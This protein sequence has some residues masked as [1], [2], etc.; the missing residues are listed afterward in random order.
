M[1]IDAN[2]Q[3][4]QGQVDASQEQSAQPQLTSLDSLSEFE[5]QGQKFTPERL[6]EMLNGYQSLSKE[7]ETYQRYK[8]YALNVDTDIENVLEGRASAE[9]FKSV[10][11]RE[12][13]EKL[14]RALQHKQGN[15]ANGIPKEFLNEFGQLKSGYE[16]M[17]EQLHQMAM[18]SANAKIEAIL[19]K[20]LDKYPLATEDMILAKAEAFLSSGG[21]MTDQAWE[22]LA[23]ESHEMID[24]RAA[25]YYKKSLQAQTEKGL[26]AKDAGPGGATP[27][28]APPKM[29]SFADAEKAMIAELKSQGYNAY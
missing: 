21:R 22:R 2:V 15:Q 4:E 18:E 19:P 27:G 13:H 8:D 26:Q 29:K 25:S 23:K 3:P 5:F 14:E 9:K 6:Q 17:R 16:Q 1:E 24:K 7:R 11:P 28:K 20:L 12:F 10:Y